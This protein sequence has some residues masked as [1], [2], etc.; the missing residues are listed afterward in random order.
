M[1]NL[2]EQ[3]KT[4]K[5]NMVLLG[6]ESWNIVLNIMTGICMAVKSAETMK[7]EIQKQDF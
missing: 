4:I 6:D 7:Q 3:A 5:K 1:S 2:T